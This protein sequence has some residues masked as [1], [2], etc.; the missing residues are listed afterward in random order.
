MQS[1]KERECVKPMEV[2]TKE[3]D[4]LKQEECEQKCENCLYYNTD[5]WKCQNKNS[6]F[7]NQE[8]KCNDTCIEQ[9]L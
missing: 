3:Q 2:N 4:I 5:N 7:Y 9:E 1:Y 8:R 6:L